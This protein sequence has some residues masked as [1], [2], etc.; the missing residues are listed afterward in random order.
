M[1][2]KAIIDLYFE[3]KE[4]AL[5]ATDQKYSGYLKKVIGGILNQKED[6]EECL[7][8]TYMAVWNRIPPERPISFRAFVAKIARY[9]AF[10]KYDYISAKRRNSVFDVILSELEECLSVGDPVEKELEA[11]ILRDALNSFLYSLEKEKRLVFLRRYWFG[12]SIGVIADNFGLSE[13]KVKTMLFR[14]RGQLKEHL[15]KEGIAV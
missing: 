15:K 14:L 7:N 2:D 6:I 4:E 10:N 9:T 8:D 12:D 3:R 5:K 1:E 13:S 11:G